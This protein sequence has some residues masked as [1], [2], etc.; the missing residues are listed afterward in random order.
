V[1]ARKNGVP[2]MAVAYVRPDAQHTS[3]TAAVVW[4]NQHLTRIAYHP[5]YQEPGGGPWPAT[6]SLTHAQRPGLIAAFNSAFRLQDSH[7]GFYGWGKTASPLQPGAASIA[8]SNTGNIHIG[9]WGSE[10]GMTP[11]TQVVRQN[12]VEIVDH[13]KP[14]KGLASNAGDQWGATLGNVYYVWRS[15]IGQTRNG[16]LMFVTGDRLSVPTLANLMVRAG[17]VRGME[18]DINPEWTSYIMYRTPTGK[19]NERNLLPDMQ[20]PSD[21]YDVSSSRDFFAVYLK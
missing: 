6:D 8:L 21:R 12:L 14:A 19:P 2:A 9:A 15:G 16:N 10:V 20:Q 3:Y 4:I 11:Q 1:L 5:G 17:V 13:G 7:G 18:L